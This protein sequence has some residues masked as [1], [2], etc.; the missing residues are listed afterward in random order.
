M[1]ERETIRQQLDRLRREM[2]QERDARERDGVSGG[3]R[4][5]DR[6]VSFFSQPCGYLGYRPQRNLRMQGTAHYS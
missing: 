6:A 1:R 4:M 3:P 2:N 5:T